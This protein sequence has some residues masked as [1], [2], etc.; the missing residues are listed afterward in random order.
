MPGPGSGRAESATIGAG[1]GRSW[2]PRDEE[3]EE[4]E[5][6]KDKDKEEEDDDDDEKEEDANSSCWLLA[7]T[8]LQSRGLG[9]DT[10]GSC[11]GNRLA[12]P[13]VIV[14]AGA[15]LAD[16]MHESRPQRRR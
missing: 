15:K 16:A 1:R 14:D 4:E 12:I 10:R 9:R 2:V 8:L 11:Q 13:A 6:D 7:A 3:E 5:E